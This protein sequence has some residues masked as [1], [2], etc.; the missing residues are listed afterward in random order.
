[1]IIYAALNST[2]KLHLHDYETE[3]DI[4]AQ[5]YARLRKDG[6]DVKAGVTYLRTKSNIGCAFDLVI[7][8]GREAAV[9]IEVKSPLEGPQTDLDASHQGLK[10]RSFGLPVVLFW[11]MAYYQNLREFVDSSLE[12]E[13]PKLKGATP[14]IKNPTTFK[15]L[16]KYLDISSMQAYDLGL[17]ELERDL[18]QKRDAIKALMV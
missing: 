10:Y 8:K 9:I 15:R 4:Q 7:H 14:F 6:F 12:K 5:L 11:D 17:S 3:A 13:T 16:H 2:E 18:E 1:M